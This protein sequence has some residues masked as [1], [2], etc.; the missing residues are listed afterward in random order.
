MYGLKCF[1]KLMPMNSDAAANSDMIISLLKIK[2]RQEAL[3]Y[4]EQIAYDLGVSN[5][6]KQ[7]LN[8]AFLTTLEFVKEVL[9]PSNPKKSEDNYPIT[10]SA[11]KNRCTHVDWDVLFEKIF[12]EA[13]FPS[14][15]EMPILISEDVNF[16]K[17]CSMLGGLLNSSH[18]KR[19]I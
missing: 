4:T 10:I 18:G 12:G 19:Y 1:K 8:D 9:I 14:Y 16:G 13:G 2:N 6:Q 11:L 17:M 15:K 3:R 7:K 5:T